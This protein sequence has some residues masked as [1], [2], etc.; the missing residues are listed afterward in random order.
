MVVPLSYSVATCIFVIMFPVVTHH[1]LTRNFKLRRPRSLRGFP[2]GNGFGR[3][4]LLV[5][6]F[7]LCTS[8]G[9]HD[10]PTNHAADEKRRR[11]R[12]CRGA[13]SLDEHFT[14]RVGVSC[15]KVGAPARRYSVHADI[16]HPRAKGHSSAFSSLS[17]GSRSSLASPASSAPEASR[18][19]TLPVSRSTCTIC[20]PLLSISIM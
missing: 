12:D 7:H 17:C 19:I 1:H 5:V 14:I 9:S 10:D 11:G 2:L 4:P 13:N 15:A 16:F 8:A 20:T 18:A 3:R 6:S